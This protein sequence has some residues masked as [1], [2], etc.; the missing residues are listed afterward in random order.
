MAYADFI[1]GHATMP[2]DEVKVTQREMDTFRYLQ[3]EIVARAK[4]THRT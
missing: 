3:G 4:V 1:H 2:A